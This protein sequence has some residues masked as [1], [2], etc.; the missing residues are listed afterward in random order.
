MPLYV[1]R[2]V[3]YYKWEVQEECDE[4]CRIVGKRN[5]KFIKINDDPNDFYMYVNCSEDKFMN[6][7]G[8]LQNIVLFRGPE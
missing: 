5:I 8:L 6:F 4:I 2:V 1:L 7:Q 3:Q